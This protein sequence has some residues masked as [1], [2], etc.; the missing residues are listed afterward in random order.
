MARDFD[1]FELA[2]MQLSFLS[3]L[4]ME[5]KERR[6]YDMKLLLGK[7]EKRV[8]I[9]IERQIKGT[10]REILEREIN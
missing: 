5:A 7:N 6:V 1:E 9:Y 8:C 2:A 3:L 4:S 10:R